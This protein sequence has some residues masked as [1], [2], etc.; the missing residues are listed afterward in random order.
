LIAP[1]KLVTALHVVASVDAPET[2]T[3]T[4]TY[5]SEALGWVDET[6]TFDPASD[7]HDTNAD[8]TVLTVRSPPEDTTVWPCRALA[9]DQQ[10]AGCRTFGFG[11]QSGNRG[12]RCQGRIAGFRIPYP[13]EPEVLY[14]H[15]ARFD[16]FTGQSGID[17]RGFSGGPVIVDGRVVGVFVSFY[18]AEKRKPVVTPEESPRLTLAEGGVADVVPIEIV[19][20]RIGMNLLQDGPGESGEAP[21]TPAARPVEAYLE[22]LRR[23]LKHIGLD[24]YASAT[25]EPAYVWPTLYEQP[26]TQNIDPFTEAPFDTAPVSAVDARRMME[27]EGARIVLVAGAGFGKTELL[28]SVALT[29]CS[30]DRVPALVSLPAYATKTK[31]M[32]LLT[33]LCDAPEH[34]VDRLVPWPKLAAEGQLV[35]LLDGLDEITQ[36]RARIIRRIHEF[37]CDHP[38]A[39]WIVTVR[40]PSLAIGVDAHQLWLLPLDKFELPDLFK[41]YLPHETADR[42]VRALETKPGLRDLCRIPLFGTLLAGQVRRHGSEVMPAGPHKLLCD[43]VDHLLDAG[44]TRPEISLVHD[45][46]LLRHA[47]Q[48]LAHYMIEREETIIAVHDARRSVATK[49]A[50]AVLADLV[51]AGLLIRSGNHLKFVLP[52]VQEFLAGEHAMD[53]DVHDLAARVSV[54]STR[55]WRQFLQFALVLAPESSDALGL[56]SAQPDDVFASRLRMVG[57]VVS[58]GAKITPALRRAIGELLAEFF[59]RCPWSL[60]I[61]RDEVMEILIS[62]FSDPLPANLVEG[63]VNRQFGY[64]I[65]DLLCCLDDQ[66]V[67]NVLELSLESEQLVFRDVVLERLMRVAAPATRTIICHVQ[68]AVMEG[69]LSVEDVGHAVAV[70]AKDHGARQ[71]LDEQ[72]AAGALPTHIELILASECG[73]PEVAREA[74]YRLLVHEDIGIYRASQRLWR[75][76]DGLELWRRVIADPAI[77]TE[78]RRYLMLGAI[79][80]WGEAARLQVHALTQTADPTLRVEGLAALAIRGDAYAFAELTQMIVAGAEFEAVVLWCMCV[81]MFENDDALAGMAAVSAYDLDDSQI[82]DLLCW[83]GFRLSHHVQDADLSGTASG[84]PRRQHHVAAPTAARLVVRISPRDG[85]EQVELLTK[86][87][88]FGDDAAVDELVHSIREQWREYEANEDWDWKLEQALVEGVTVLG[89]TRIDRATLEEMIQHSSWNL[90]QAAMRTYLRLDH[91]LETLLRLH[92]GRSNEDGLLLESIYHEALACGL[93]LSAAQL[94]R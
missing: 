26:N 43:F 71:I 62:A 25:R 58:W 63:L 17:P 75:R 66:A 68:Q 19:L 48:R 18:D 9:G 38:R 92:R 33:Y 10:S 15:R 81:C 31:E 36:H 29:T 40:D 72:Q 78:T 11:G 85:R 6:V 76:S 35:L 65:D 24:G 83:L 82:R 87:V 55:P 73:S 61:L 23:R 54:N 3:L 94:E 69:S 41:G 74:L 50:D 64:D 1:D 79:D 53:S 12:N 32:G 89:E 60:H 2:T 46:Q 52:T 49:E 80:E 13:T 90:A 21:A 20:E 8:W 86:R 34:E 57:R 77:T 91:D 70:L 84:L 37:A 39:R 5:Y 14:R 59:L 22:H 27:I 44:R 45:P 16:E 7:P 28:H 4:C 30:T 42:L 51:C 88:S 67:L 56:I 93:E 47:A